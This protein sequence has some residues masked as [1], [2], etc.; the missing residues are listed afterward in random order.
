MDLDHF[1]GRVHRGG[2]DDRHADHVGVALRHSFGCDFPGLPGRLPGVDERRP[3]FGGPVDPR[4]Q[5]EPG[6]LGSGLSEALRYREG[7]VVEH[8]W[9]EGRFSS[10]PSG[11]WGSLP[12]SARTGLGP[13]LSGAPPVFA[14]RWGA[15]DILRVRPRR[16]H[17][18]RVG[19]SAAHGR[20]LLPSPPRSSRR[21]LAPAPASAR[22]IRRG[23]PRS[24]RRRT[25][26]RVA[27]PAAVCN[28]TSHRSCIDTD[29]PPRMLRRRM[30]TT[31]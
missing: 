3:E 30:E 18:P 8:D 7:S 25:A 22:L 21:T 4:L 16:W 24:L 19:C 11:H 5:P 15:G 20:S 13:E 26:R 10:A 14:D 27:N 29:Q 31:T 23:G 28:D 12:R 9:V 2:L 6:F 17:S 1:Q